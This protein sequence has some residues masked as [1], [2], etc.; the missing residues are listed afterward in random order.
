MNSGSEDRLTNSCYPYT[1]FFSLKR[2]YLIL[3]VLLEKE[4]TYKHLTKKNPFSKNSVSNCAVGPILT[5]FFYY[6]CLW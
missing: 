2:A 3:Y 1:Q 5:F 6:L 4:Q